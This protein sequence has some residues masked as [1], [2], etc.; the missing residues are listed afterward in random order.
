MKNYFEFYEIP[1]EFKVDKKALKH[2]F[3]A[4]SK[5]YHPDFHTDKSVEEQSMIL[6]LSTLNNEAYQVLKDFDLRMK[7][8]LQ[9]K[10]ML[11]EGKDKLPQSFLMEMM[12]INEALMELQFDPNPEKLN[13]AQNNINQLKESFY[14]P[15]SALI[16]NYQDDQDNEEELELIKNYFLKHRYILRIQNNLDKFATAS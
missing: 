6:A 15:I 14:L 8:I 16:D 11:D 12:D 2:K 4:L 13:E 9:L 1:I 7:Y 10:N 5:K 3:Y